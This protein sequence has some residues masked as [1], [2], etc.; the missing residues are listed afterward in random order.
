MTLLR[1]TCI[2]QT[3]RAGRR[4]RSDPTINTQQWRLTDGASGPCPTHFH[5][6]CKLVSELA[7]Q[8]YCA[9][10]RQMLTFGQTMHGRLNCVCKRHLYYA[11]I[12]LQGVDFRIADSDHSAEVRAQLSTTTISFTCQ[13][14]D[15]DFCTRGSHHSGSD[16]T[17]TANDRYSD[18]V[19]QVIPKS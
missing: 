12:D 18:W 5:R 11:D 4:M 15:K 9:P 3:I 16:A 6:I 1:R 10:S 7:L 2:E 17:L 13:I 19:A 14:Q 8:F